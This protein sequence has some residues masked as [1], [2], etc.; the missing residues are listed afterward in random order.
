LEEQEIK[1]VANRCNNPPKSALSYPYNEHG[2]KNP[3]QLKRKCNC[4]Y[5]RT[6]LSNVPKHFNGTTYRTLEGTSTLAVC[7]YVPI[8]SSSAQPA[9][10]HGGKKH[11]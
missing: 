6:F 8:E 5:F 7:N 10:I 4:Y 1:T 9:I 11:L 3:A 2:T